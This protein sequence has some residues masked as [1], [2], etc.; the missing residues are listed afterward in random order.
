MAEKEVLFE[1]NMETQAQ[2]FNNLQDFIGNSI[3]HI[4]VDAI[5]TGNYYT[6]LT[7]SKAA[8]TQISIAIGRLYWGGFVYVLEDPVIID[9]QSIA[10][11]MPVTQKRQI[12]IVAW[13]STIMTDTQPRNFV[14]DADTGQAQ[15]QSVSMTSIRLCNVG[16]IPG[17]EAPSPNT[18]AVPATN[19]LIA[20]VLLDPSG[21]VSVQQEGSTQLANLT[22]LANTVGM[23]LSWQSIINGQI[24][25]LQT[26]LAALAA[27]LSNYCTLDMFG[28]LAD[29][30]NQ[31][32]LLVNRPATYLL[33][34]IDNYFDTSQSAV[35][36]NVDGAY[37]AFIADG[38]RFP[39]GQSVVT[40]LALR[41]PTEP[42]IQAWDTFVLPKP[43]GSRIRMDCSFP[44]FPLIAERILAHPYWTFSPRKL[45]WA[46][47]RFRCGIPF[48]PCPSPAVFTWTGTLDPVFCNLRFD[49]RDTWP[50]VP[51]NTVQKYPEDDWDF[52]RYT[53]FRNQYY[54]TDHVDVYYWSKVYA[55]LTYSHNHFGQSFLN[56]QDGWLSGIT[57]FSH[58]PSFYQPLSLNIYRCDDQGVPD[59]QQCVGKIDL[60]GPGVQGCYGT[61][62]YA[63]DI[64][65]PVFEL[66]S[67]IGG[68]PGAPSPFNYQSNSEVVI[69][70]NQDQSGNWHVYYRFR[71]GVGIVAP[72]RI[73]FSPVFLE[74]GK[75]YSF[76]LMSTFDHQFSVCNDFSCYGVHQGDFWEYDGGSWFR[77]VPGGPRSLRFMLHYLVWGQW[78]QQQSPSGQLRYDVDLVSLQLPTG[79]QSIDVLAEH[80]IPN[81]TDLSYSVQ[82]GN[83]WYPFAGDPDNPVLTN[84]TATALLPFRMTFTGTTDVMPGVSLVNSQVKL[85]AYAGNGFYHISTNIPRAGATTSGIKVIAT[86]TNYNSAH[87]T[88]T[89]AL[90]TA[91]GRKTPDTVP[92]V[93]TPMPDGVSAQYVW[94]FT[95]ANG[96][97][98]SAYQVELTGGTDGTGNAYVVSQRA[99]YSV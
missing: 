44:D 5:A 39:A 75:R 67:Q 35:G 81:A 27:R 16:P 90:H 37:N 65:G 82:V 22:N 56:S 33:D 73:N 49:T 19:L 96:T 47:D 71:A 38:I 57:L 15:P 91:G 51:C 87:H 97:G 76:H 18:P 78:G 72:L 89:C 48:T 1:D 83:I 58:A 63:G 17:V 8:S 68:V 52:P 70:Q 61:P 3:D 94:S 9:F 53:Q 43:S 92:T 59:H 46:R 13:G 79:I 28:K 95:G 2:D 20:T 26:T 99:A 11:A 12:A 85:Q 7:V 69:F 36:T 24:S 14:V 66:V 55:N 34:T 21:V 6:G 88:L 31:I 86:V 25:T 77:V 74:A 54:W 80:I 30:V 32:W 41:N 42:V 40:Q 10:G 60:D 45:N 29:L 4:V 50:G 64:L 84:P 98:I 23:L 93:P 62:I